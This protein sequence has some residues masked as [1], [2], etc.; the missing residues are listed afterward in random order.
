MNSGLTIAFI[1]SG[2]KHPTVENY[3][4]F[5]KGF[6]KNSGYLPDEFWVGRSNGA[7]RL[8]PIDMD[9]I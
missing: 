2:N 9:E 8:H 1:C 6:F 7:G 3:K 4:K 5:G